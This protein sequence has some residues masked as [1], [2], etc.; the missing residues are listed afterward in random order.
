MIH[1]VSPLVHI[2]KEVV[3][4][5]VDEIYFQLEK[6]YYDIDAVGLKVSSI[7]NEYALEN[8]AYVLCAHKQATFMKNRL[9]NKKIDAFVLETN[10][11]S[12]IQISM[13]EDQ[14]CL[15]M[16]KEQIIDEQAFLILCG[17]CS[18]SLKDYDICVMEYNETSISEKV[19]EDALKTI[20]LKHPIMVVDVH[21]MYLKLLKMYPVSVLLIDKTQYLAYFGKSEK[22]AL[23]TMIENIKM[24]MMDMADLII[25]TLS[26]NDFIIFTKQE[27]IRVVCS[28]KYRD[29]PIY[30]EALLSAIV[31]CYM[32]DGNLYELSKECLSFSVNLS[33]HGKC[34][35]HDFD[36]SIH[37]YQ[38]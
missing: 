25:Y 24:Q 19:M 2:K 5:N 37:V 14:K 15:N 9:K 33:L 16:V 3:G 6:V 1:I 13:V 28:C 23:S 31:K 26:F 38:I 35:M 4:R 21:A 7:L 36:E 10:E 34:N 20:A 29:L 8:K 32:H 17:M 11:I 22:E 30:K 12:D 18:A 27:V